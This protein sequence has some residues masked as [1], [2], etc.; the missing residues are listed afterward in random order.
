MKANRSTF[1]KLT[2]VLDAG[3][4]QTFSVSV[5]LS[6][7]V[8]GSTEAGTAEEIAEWLCDNFPLTEW[9]QVVYNGLTGAQA[10]QFNRALEYAVPGAH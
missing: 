5:W 9:T 7:S 2:V 1:D 8:V 3:D 6:G 10:Q 4:E